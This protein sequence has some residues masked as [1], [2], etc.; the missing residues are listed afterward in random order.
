MTYVC[1]PC[2]L[3]RLDS[4]PVVQMAET[5]YSCTLLALKLLVAFCPEGGPQQP[6]QKGWPQAHILTALQVSSS[7]L[8]NS[9]A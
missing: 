4:I 9:Y 5:M 1:R 6:K 7:C 3:V 8:N 2:G